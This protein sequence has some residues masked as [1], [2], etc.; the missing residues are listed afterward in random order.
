MQNGDIINFRFNVLCTVQN[1]NYINWIKPE[2]KG[3]NLEL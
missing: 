1:T 2:T 3:I